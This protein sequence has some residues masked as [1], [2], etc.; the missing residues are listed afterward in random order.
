MADRKFFQ[1]VSRNN[2]IN[3]NPF[4]LIMVY[5]SRSYMT[6][7]FEARSSSPDVVNTLLNG[8]AEQIRQ[9]HLAPG[10][11]N[12]LKRDLTKYKGMKLINSY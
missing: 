7:L 6:E 4:R 8:G 9:L 5:D 2:D 3:G 11:Y 12:E 10:I 1:V